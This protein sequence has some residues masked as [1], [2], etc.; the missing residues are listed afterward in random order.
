MGFLAHYEVRDRNVQV[1]QV[2]LRTNGES[3]VDVLEGE[4]RMV[5][6][7]DFCFK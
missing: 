2:P 4:E 6:K 5:E 7:A 3:E 1:G